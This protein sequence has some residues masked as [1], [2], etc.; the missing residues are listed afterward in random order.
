MLEVCGIIFLVKDD[1]TNLVVC[2][3]FWDCPGVGSAGAFLFGSTKIFDF[4]EIFFP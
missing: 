3:V 1:Y 2:I 4:S